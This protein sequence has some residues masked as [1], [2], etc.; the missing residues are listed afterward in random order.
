MKRC[1][2]V[3]HAQ[4]AWNQ[5]NRLQ[6]KTDLSLDLTGQAQAQALGEW[7]AAKPLAHVVTSSLARAR[8]TADAIVSASGH[9][10]KPIVDSAFEEMN[11]GVW[12][13]LT[14]DQVEQNFPGAYRQ[15]RIRP[16]SVTIPEGEAAEIF[17][18]RVEDAFKRLRDT[19]S[20]DEECV[21]VTHG[22]VIAAL[23]A[24]LLQGSYDTFLCRLRLDNAGVTII[25]SGV[26]FPHVLQI[27]SVS[28]LKI[29]SPN[30]QD[31][32]IPGVAAKR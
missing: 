25:E 28:H 11:L 7:F 2:L 10:L 20:Q 22:G 13:G 16:S 32:D 19:V 3:R 23:L 27:N 18:S 17:L 9:R 6:G 1:Y 15:W 26:R 29:L 31:L 4:T 8:Q 21:V 5:E 12:E 30:P 14:A 24:H